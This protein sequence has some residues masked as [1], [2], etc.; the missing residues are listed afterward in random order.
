MDYYQIAVLLTQSFLN[1]LVTTTVLAFWLIVMGLM[2]WFI[3]WA[4]KWVVRFVKE[5]YVDTVKEIW[6]GKKAR[7]A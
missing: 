1:I 4:A 5:Q 2:A 6:N 3:M 7:A